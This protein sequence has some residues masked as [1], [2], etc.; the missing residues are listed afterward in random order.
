MCPLTTGLNGICVDLCGSDNDCPGPKKCCS[1]DCGRTCQIPIPAVQSEG[2]CPVPI[3]SEIACA[4]I[5]FVPCSG[6]S[7]CRGRQKCCNI[8]CGNTCL[9]PARTCAVCVLSFYSRES[10]NKISIISVFN[11]L[12]LP[13]PTLYLS[14]TCFFVTLC[15]QF[16]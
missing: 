14:D 13:V 2:T 7:D 11:V 12:K 4:F 1:H 10:D 9:D 5:T 8:G 15:H 16:G 3:F 6:N